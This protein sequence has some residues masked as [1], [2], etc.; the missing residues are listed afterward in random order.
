MPLDLFVLRAENI[1]D[2]PYVDNSSEASLLRLRIGDSVS[3]EDFKRIATPISM[4]M[5]SFNVLDLL[6]SG[7]S[8]K[9]IVATDGEET[10]NIRGFYHP[11]ILLATA[12]RSIASLN[13]W[14]SAA[15][16]PYA[17]IKNLLMICAN[18]LE[19]NQPV[20][21]AGFD[22]I[23]QNL[24]ESFPRIAQSAAMIAWTTLLRDY[25][26]PTVHAVVNF[27]TSI[28]FGNTKYVPSPSQEELEY[29]FRTNLWNSG[30]FSSDHSALVES[31]REIHSPRIH[32][33]SPLR[34]FDA[35]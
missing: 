10:L 30:A 12:I 5:D 28:G 19:T 29:L 33:P 13:L 26:V 25:Y 8:V 24:I 27:Y 34:Y 1:A 3:R 16:A 18:S 6:A 4:Y 21:S 9:I 7:N 23:K 11:L 20:S 31:L 17:F 14:D 35:K 2:S 15:A 32:N 22:G